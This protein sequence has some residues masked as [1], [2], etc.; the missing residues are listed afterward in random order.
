CTTSLF[1]T[2][3]GLIAGYYPRIGS[4][5]C[6]VLDGLMAFPA[7]L[8]AIALVGALGANLLNE[9]IALTVVYTPRTTRLLR[10]AALQLRSAQYVEA[11]AAVGASDFRILIQHIFPNATAPL[12]V[13]STF[14]CA[15]AILADASL[16]FLGLGVR[17]PTP[18]W[19][20]MLG[21]GRVYLTTGP[22]F[23][24]FPGIAIIV[25]VLALNFVGDTV[26]DLLDPFSSGR[27][28][29]D[30]ASRGSDEIQAISRELSAA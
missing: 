5:I 26:R 3:L 7:I 21:E 8:L 22:W 6:R 24:I 12:I 1:G 18:T 29:T 20:N 15:E 11:A 30:D 2:T 13:Q 27:S 9:I 25:S 4:V 23:T 17:P 14:I 16:S 10:A 28:P 19:G